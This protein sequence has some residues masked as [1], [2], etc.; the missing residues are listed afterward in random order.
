M[1]DW[2]TLVNGLAIA[3][4]TFGFI[5]MLKS[6]KRLKLRRGVF[7][8]HV[9]VDPETNQPPPTSQSAPIPEVINTGI[10]FVIVGLIGQVIAMFVP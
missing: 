6:T 5:L 8:A 2:Q 4:E 7:M 3:S 9:Y 1:S 10:G